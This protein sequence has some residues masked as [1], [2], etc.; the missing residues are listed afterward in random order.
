MHREEEAMRGNSPTEVL[1]KRA[2]EI[3][4]VSRFVFCLSSGGITRPL[5]VSLTP[6]SKRKHV[7]VKDMTT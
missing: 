3:W 1:E 6:I 2:K 5:T 7:L 4:N